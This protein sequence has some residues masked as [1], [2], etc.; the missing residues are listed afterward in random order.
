MRLRPASRALAHPEERAGPKLDTDPLVP[1]ALILIRITFKRGM[2]AILFEC[3]FHSVESSHIAN[4]IP[5]MPLHKDVLMSLRLQYLATMGALFFFL[6][7]TF[8]HPAYGYTDPGSAILVFQGLSAFI[9][10]SLIYFRKR[11]RKLI[12]EVKRPEKRSE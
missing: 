1:R 10:G 4:G 6:A 11:L 8:E 12:N 3:N 5:W 7:L 2:S 9:T